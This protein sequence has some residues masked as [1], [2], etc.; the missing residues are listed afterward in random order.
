MKSDTSPF[1]VFVRIRPIFSREN[2]KKSVRS[3]APCDFTTDL[4]LTDPITSSEKSFSYNGVFSERFSNSEVYSYSL[5]KQIPRLLNGCNTTCFAYGSTGAGK[6][7]TMF[8]H[9][10]NMNSGISYLSIQDLFKLLPQVPKKLSFLEIYNETIIDLL[11]IKSKPLMIV[12]DPIRGVVVPDLMEFTVKS[13]EEVQGLIQRG[14]RNRAKA[15][16]LANECSTRSHG[17]LQI[18]FEISKGGEV[19]ISKLCLIDLAGSERAANTENR[20]IR[21]KEGANI[22]RSLLA[23]GNCINILSDYRKKGAYVPFRDSKLTRLL[24]ESLGGNSKT[25]MVACI[26]P[27]Q[28]AYEDTT[29]TLKYASRAKNITTVVTKVV[30]NSDYLE[31]INSLKSEIE[32]LR[33]QLGRDTI[34]KNIQPLEII[35]SQKLTQQIVSN[36]E[37][38]WELKQSIKEIED[39][40]FQNTRLLEENRDEFKQEFLRNNIVENECRKNQLLQQLYGNMKQKQLLQN[41]IS[42]IKDDTKREFLELQIQVRTLKLEKIDLFVQNNNFK[43]EVEEV[44]K[45]SNRKDQIILQMQAELESMKTKIDRQKSFSGFSMNTFSPISAER[46]TPEIV[47]T[48]S[49]NKIPTHRPHHSLKQARDIKKLKKRN[50]SI[51]SGTESFL[52]GYVT[53]NK[54]TE[55]DEEFEEGKANIPMPSNTKLRKYSIGGIEDSKIAKQGAFSSLQV[56]SRAGSAGKIRKPLKSK[57]KAKASEVTMSHFIKSKRVLQ[58]R[59]INITTRIDNCIKK[60]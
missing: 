35:D 38:H 13:L 34:I 49:V 9:G 8:G 12:E 2:P 37:E 32:I 27:L 47:F 52:T 26:S 43:Q 18:I 58:K 3:K 6:T 28:S 44:K 46:S 11:S 31:I 17:V 19:L 48:A 45:E 15:A 10:S 59:D 55:N 4:F 36:F 56:A 51:D 1:E 16:T 33:I 30:K 60:A 41:Q 7:H 39:L 5:Q 22:N 40:N 21:M 29:Q 20:G 14:N 50:G 57:P 53:V 24:K 23:L 54:I 42:E 25:I